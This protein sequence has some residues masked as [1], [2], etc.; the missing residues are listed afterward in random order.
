MNEKQAFDIVNQGI[1]LALSN[2]AFK[3]SRDVAII[4][5][6][7]EVVAKFLVANEELTKEYT[8]PTGKSSEINSPI[9]GEKPE[10]QT[11]SLKTE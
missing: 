5:Q 7:L 1:N 11:E 6:A 10:S 8:A 2:G 9:M 4:S 3:N